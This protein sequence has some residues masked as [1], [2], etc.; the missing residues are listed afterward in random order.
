MGTIFG[1]GGTTGRSK[2]V[3]WDNLTWETLIAQAA[4]NIMPARHDVAPVNLCAAP[5]THAAGVL[6][7]MLLP[8]APTNIVLERPS[9]LEIWEAIDK[10]GVT[11]LY[12]PPTL[13][14]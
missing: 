3:R 2:A 1:T 10:H 7:M 14:Y 4:M 6:A 12:V 9:P 11:H 5:M 13:L 8:F